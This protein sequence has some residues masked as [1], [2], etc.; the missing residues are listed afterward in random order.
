MEQLL[1]LLEELVVQDQREVQE[2]QVDRE[3]E[4]MVSVVR[5]ELVV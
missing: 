3:V 4:K 1:L 2:V 5:A